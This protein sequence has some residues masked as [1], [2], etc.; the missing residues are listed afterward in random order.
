MAWAWLY[1]VI[2]TILRRFE[3]TLYNTTRENVEMVQDN[4]SGQTA[5]GMNKVQVKVRQEN[6]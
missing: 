1:L 4:F 6:R 3:L 5:E 2:G